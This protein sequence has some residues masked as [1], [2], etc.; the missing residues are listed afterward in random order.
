MRPL[1]K[2]THNGEVLSDYHPEKLYR[3][4]DVP[5][6]SDKVLECLTLPV[7]DNSNN[8]TNFN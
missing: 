5:L 2:L 1:Q 6:H 3:L 8:I 7:Y 4:H